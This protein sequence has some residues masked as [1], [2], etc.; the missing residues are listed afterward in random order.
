[1]FHESLKKQFNWKLMLTYTVKLTLNQYLMK[2]T[3]RNISQ[4]SFSLQFVAQFEF[5]N[6]VQQIVEQSLSENSLTD[7]PRY[8]LTKVEM[9][10]KGRNEWKKE[11]K[12]LDAVK[13]MYNYFLDVQIKVLIGRYFSNLFQY[14]FYWGYYEI[15]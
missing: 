4:L 8:T 6:V 3:E 9:P 7:N 5:T 15:G 1:M 14:Q 2:Y 13:R 12:K 10:R 11:E